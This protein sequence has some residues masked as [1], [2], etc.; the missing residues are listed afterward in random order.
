MSPIDAE[1][2]FAADA[3]TLGQWTAFAKWSADD[4]VM[5]VPQPTNA[6]AWLKDRKDPSKA[7]DWWPTASYISCDG[8]LAINK[9]EWKRPDGRIG[10]FTTV[11]QRQGDG[12]WKWIV[13]SGNTLKALPERP[14]GP[15]VVRAFCTTGFKAESVDDD[16]MAIQEAEGGSPDKTLHW[17]WRLA[18]DGGRTLVAWIYD[19]AK[20]QPIFT[21]TIPAPPR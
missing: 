17:R 5:F 21:D 6:H 19:G 9:G 14:A 11:W 20:L 7:I 4:A 1:R 18:D 3:Q 8:M 10:Y 13:D 12:G 2:T 15:K 16:V